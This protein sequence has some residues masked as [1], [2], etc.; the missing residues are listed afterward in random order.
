MKSW[1]LWERASGGEEDR[2][3]EAVHPSEK[4]VVKR[5]YSELVDRVGEGV[6]GSAEEDV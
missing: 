3:D 2:M 5:I 6:G 4:G 1:G